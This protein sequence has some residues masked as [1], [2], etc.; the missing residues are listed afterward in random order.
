M[1]RLFR[2]L[3]TLTLVLSLNTARA[4]VGP[5]VASFESDGV[6]ADVLEHFPC[7][8]KAE[9]KAKAQTAMN[10]IGASCTACHAAH[11]KQ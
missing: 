6:V 3:T 9:G 8:A 5:P 4:A 1:N 11:K 7:A 2:G 10:K